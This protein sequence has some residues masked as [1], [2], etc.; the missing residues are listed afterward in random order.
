MSWHSPRAPVPNILFAKSP[1]ESAPMTDDS[2]IN[3]LQI[4]PQF[5]LP[6]ADIP[7]RHGECFE[8]R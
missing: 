6:E 7:A 8:P 5:P 3:V 4:K 2:T 1:I